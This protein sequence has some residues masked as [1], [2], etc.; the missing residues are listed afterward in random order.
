V[1]LVNAPIRNMPP[2]SVHAIAAIFFVR[3]FEVLILGAGWN[4]LVARF[5]H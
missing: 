1:N 2:A 4:K 5:G 3:W